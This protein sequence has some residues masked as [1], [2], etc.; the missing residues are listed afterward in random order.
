MP[1]PPQRLQ[2][3]SSCG[4]Q[5]S[6]FHE[7]DGTVLP[8]AILAV[9]AASICHSLQDHSKLPAALSQL[10]SQGWESLLSHGWSFPDAVVAI[11][12]HSVVSFLTR[13]YNY[14]HP[15]P[16]SQAPPGATRKH[17]SGNELTRIKRALYRVE[18]YHRLFAPLS[19]LPHDELRR[20]HTFFFSQFA[21]WENEQLASFRERP[22]EEIERH[23]WPLSRCLPDA[24]TGPADTT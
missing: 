13:I 19:E 23:C 10:F 20:A 1:H 14:M 2:Q 6:R 16:W 17:F 24:A 21:S 12:L 18:T 7:I 9:K 3:L 4:G 15:V 22:L 5:G 11:R 8:E